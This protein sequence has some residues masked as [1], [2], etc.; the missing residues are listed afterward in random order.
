MKPIKPFLKWAGGKYRIIHH[1]LNALPQEGKRLVEPFTGSGAVFVN[2]HFKRYL[3]AEYNLDLIQLFQ[4]LQQEG[5]A[6]IQYCANLF[7]NG[8]HEA[9]YY[10]RRTAFNACTTSRERAALFLY[11]NRHGYNGLCRYNQKGKFNVPFG[12]YIKPYFPEKEMQHFK[13]KSQFAKF[14]HQDFRKTFETLR[15]GDVVYCDP[16]YI[17]LSK[18]ASFTTYTQN[19]FTQNDQITLAALAKQAATAGHTIIISNHDTPF[20]RE[21]YAGSQIYTFPV[22]RFI[23][24]QTQFGRPHVTELIA[25]FRPTT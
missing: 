20:I 11:L 22:R 3:L 14:A 9:L 5:D 12:R 23:S 2:A 6:F 25:V 13:H 1:I 21:Q 7:E 10:E 8:N 19:Q 18:S 4:H 16:P 24:C 15:K 17:P